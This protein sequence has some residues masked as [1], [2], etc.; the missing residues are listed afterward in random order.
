MAGLI[1]GLSIGIG[2]TFGLRWMVSDIDP[3]RL[4]SDDGLGI[5]NF[6][7]SASLAPVPAVPEPATWAM[8]I[9]GFGMIG[10]TMRHR[11]RTTVGFA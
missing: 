10:G 9:A 2:D 11:K 8:M 3:V 4:S 1:D 6:S 5:D 7:M